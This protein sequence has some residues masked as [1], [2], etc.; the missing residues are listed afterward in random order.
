VCRQLTA[1]SVGDRSG[2]G[3]R[4]AFVLSKGVERQSSSLTPLHRRKSSEQCQGS[5]RHLSIT[6]NLPISAL[7]TSPSSFSD[8]YLHLA[9][10]REGINPTLRLQRCPVAHTLNAQACSSLIG[11][12]FICHPHDNLVRLCSRIAY[13]QLMKILFVLT[14][15][16]LLFKPPDL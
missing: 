15:T 4:R 1:Y 10:L 16:S 8:S 11:L 7:L 14:D 13:R 6:C 3:G 2:A 5:P 12:H 9:L